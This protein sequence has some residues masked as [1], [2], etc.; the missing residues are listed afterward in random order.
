MQGR[1]VN[2]CPSLG[3]VNIVSGGSPIGSVDA[4]VT[5]GWQSYTNVSTIVTFVN[6]GTQ[7]VR[8]NFNGDAGFLY[9]ILSLIHI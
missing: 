8:L 5:G 6:A 4:A 9:N 3:H 2:S 1:N 7:A